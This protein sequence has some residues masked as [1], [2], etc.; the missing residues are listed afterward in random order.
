MTYDCV[1]IK[2]I[3]GTNKIYE[4][5]TEKAQLI[6]LRIGHVKRYRDMNSGEGMI[7][8][9]RIKNQRRKRCNKS[10]YSWESIYM[11]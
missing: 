6:L 5:I 7:K 11:S 2:R 8:A 4:N 9:K 10:M 3:H 1:R